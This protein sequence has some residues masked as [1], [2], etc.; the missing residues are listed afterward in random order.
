MCS[1]VT[2]D[3]PAQGISPKRKAF[4]AAGIRHCKDILAVLLNGVIRYRQGLV[5]F[6]VAP[7][8]DGNHLVVVLE[9]VH[10]TC[11]VPDLPALKAAVQQKDG[12]SGPVDIIGNP[13]PIG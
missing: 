13:D 9:P 5:T 11:V 6:A 12:R 7:D 2:R 3:I 1:Q 8:I 4:D 10:V